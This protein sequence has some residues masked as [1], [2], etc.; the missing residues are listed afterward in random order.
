MGGE[1]RV[2]LEWRGALR[3]LGLTSK[4]LDWDAEQVAVQASLSIIVARKVH[5][6]RLTG[7][8][9]IVRAAVGIEQRWIE[10]RWIRSPIRDGP[11]QR[12]LRQQFTMRPMHQVV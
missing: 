5:V 2:G 1:M 10:I 9:E 12:N 7:G 11:G 3:R 6:R 4:E 8:L